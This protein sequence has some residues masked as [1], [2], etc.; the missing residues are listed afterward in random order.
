[1]AGPRAPR[2]TGL[3]RRFYASCPP[4]NSPP[5][6]RF[7]LENRLLAFLLLVALVGAG[8]VVSPFGWDGLDSLPRAPIAVDAI[9]DLGENQQ[10]V[11]TNP[12]AAVRR[13][14]KTKLPI[15]S[16]APSSAC[17]ELAPC[18]PTRCLG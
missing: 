16:P 8:I 17:P 7:F 18:A 3:P 1:M 11:F 14:L 9:P 2:P 5:L 4:A 13:T 15:P 6:V 12:P 10:I